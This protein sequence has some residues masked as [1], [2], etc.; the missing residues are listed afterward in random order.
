MTSRLVLTATKRPLQWTTST[1][2]VVDIRLLTDWATPNSRVDEDGL[3]RGDTSAETDARTVGAA[4]STEGGVVE[5]IF[6]ADAENVDAVEHAESS[7][8][9]TAP[10][11]DT[12]DARTSRFI[13]GR[14]IA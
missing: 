4:L 7:I 14:Y 2:S 1:I 11:A 13:E 6:A 10:Q 9:T 12:S 8:T 5:E 3:E